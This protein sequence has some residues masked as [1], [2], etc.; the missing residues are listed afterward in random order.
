MIPLFFI[1][2]VTGLCIM[3]SALI[4]PE[5]TWLTYYKGGMIGFLISGVILS[6]VNKRR[7]KKEMEDNKK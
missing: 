2:I 4:T 5:A 3:I 6:F 7:R 1:L